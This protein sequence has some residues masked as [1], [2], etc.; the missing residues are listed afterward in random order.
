MYKNASLIYLLTLFLSLFIITIYTSISAVI[1][2]FSPK[3]MFMNNLF[4][5]STSISAVIVMFSP[6]NVHEQFIFKFI[7]YLFV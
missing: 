4:L 1:V 7:H 6:K 5:S 2:M 3:K